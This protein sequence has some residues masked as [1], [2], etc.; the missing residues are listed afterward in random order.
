MWLI[1][2]CSCC[3][4]RCNICVHSIISIILLLLLLLLLF[5]SYHLRVHSIIS[6]T[7]VIFVLSSSSASSSSSPSSLHYTHNTSE[8]H[9]FAGCGWQHC[10]IQLS[11]RPSPTAPV[12]ADRPH[13]M[14]GTCCVPTGESS[15]ILG[16][17]H[18]ITCRLLYREMC[19]WFGC[20]TSQQHASV[21]QGRICSDNWT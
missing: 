16:R 4:C 21:S 3:R 15:G 5:L 12:F 18:A 7:F 19:L 17:Q 9:V 1:S 14:T 13:C 11:Q 2:S 6:I 20:L 10:N 8:S